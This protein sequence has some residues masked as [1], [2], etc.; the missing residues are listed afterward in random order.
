MKV[1]IR[2]EATM[3][4]LRPTEVTAYLRA[5]GWNQQERRETWAAWVKDDD[6]S[7]LFRSVANFEISR[8]AWG[9]CCA[10]YR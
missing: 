3:A 9:R 8:F 6:L 5:S 4:A 10:H 1:D 7:L 2:D